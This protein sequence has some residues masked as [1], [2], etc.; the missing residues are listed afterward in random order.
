MPNGLYKDVV[1]EKT[2]NFY[3]FHMIYT[4]Q[5]ILLILQIM[6]G[7][8]LTA[9]GA[10]SMKD[11][12]PITALAA[13]NTVAAGVLALMHSSGVPDRLLRNKNEYSNV[14]DYVK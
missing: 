7:A 5:W 14:V 12:I 13:I 11:K 9:L 2:K 3:H 10:I 8:V 1:F 4:T 6:L